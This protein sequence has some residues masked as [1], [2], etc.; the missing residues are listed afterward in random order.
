MS[1]TGP[2]DSDSRDPVMDLD[3]RGPVQDPETTLPG[4]GLSQ[5]PGINSIVL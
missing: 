2:L 1:C 4:R 3:S 5:D